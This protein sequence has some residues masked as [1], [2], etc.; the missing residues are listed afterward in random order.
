MKEKKHNIFYKTTN[1][2]NGKYYYGIHSTN[3]LE[4]GYL[5][6]GLALKNSIKKYGKEN[7]IKEIIADYSTRKEASDHEKLVVTFDL[8]KLPESYNIK[9]GGDNECTHSEE[10]RKRM[11][12]TRKG[13]YCGVNHYLF[14]KHLSDETKQRLRESKKNIGNETREK[15]RISR[16]GK[17]HKIET[18][19][20]LKKI[21]TGELNAFYGKTHTDE[22]KLNIA[23]NNPNRKSCQI[24]SIIYTS[25]EEAARQLKIPTST[26]K[27]RLK[28]LTE[29]WSDW[30]YVTD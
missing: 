21:N 20:K 25:A 7:F 13:R 16:I 30:K 5:G 22:T 9:T 12:Y 2:I 3:N 23:L 6:S 11:C 26:I 1:T 27:L 28:S 14:G 18:I 17:R 19:V 8:T 29:K 15:I 24:L 4:D 10:T